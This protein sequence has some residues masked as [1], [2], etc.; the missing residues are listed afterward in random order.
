M[1]LINALNISA[2]IAKYLVMEGIEI[3]A[4]LSIFVKLGHDMSIMS[5]D[6]LL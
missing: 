5:A 2:A 3:K 1:N 6:D 4:L